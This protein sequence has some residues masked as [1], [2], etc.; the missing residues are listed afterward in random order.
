M[1][2]LVERL[3]PQSLEAEQSVLGAM[4]LEKE[5]VIKAADL[6]G[7]DDFYR[8]AHRVIF[9]AIASLVDRGEAAD[10]VTV[11]EELRRLGQLEAVGGASYLTSLANAVP[12]A[13]NV[14]HYARIVGEKSVLRRLIQVATAIA[15][16][17]YEGA[18]EVEEL[19]DEAEQGVFSISQRLKSPGFSPLKAVLVET[20]ERL[21]YL[22][23]NKGK[24]IGVPTGFPDLDE[25]TSGLQPSELIVLAARPAM[26]KTTLSL[27]IAAHAAVVSRI[28]VAIFSLEMARQQVA[29]RMLCAEAQVEGHRLR[30]GYLRDED[31]PK[32]SRALG[33]LSEAPV[34]VDDTPN[35]SV[36][37]LRARARR[38]KAEHRVGLVVVDYLQLMHTRGRAESRQQEISEITRALKALARELSIPV[39]ALSQ[40]SRAVEQREGRRPQLSDLRESG[41]IEQDADVV[42]FI[43]FD[44]KAPPEER[45]R[46]AEIIVAKQ[47]NG[48]TDSVNL[49]FLREV[50]RFFSFEKKRRAVEVE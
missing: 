12:T 44:P 15:A 46:L 10:L 3:P 36:M 1:S 37:E 26:G 13:A 39:L 34:F 6:V 50:A 18:G 30:T 33:R 21:E 14:E 7:P 41:A 29:L 4:L 9:R 23:E 19:L 11:T 16:R 42:I 49:V 27:N 20:F 28:P 45:N 47:R 38:L 17:A 8:E 43:H 40:L 22:Y 24:A 2:T 5:A 35:L 32:L 31:W 48:P 25:L